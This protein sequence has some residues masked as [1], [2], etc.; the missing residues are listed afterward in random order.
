VKSVGKAIA[1]IPIIGHGYCATKCAAK[2][3]IVSV[4]A[5]ALSVASAAL[6]TAHYV[7]KGI[8][9]VWAKILELGSMIFK[10]NN[11]TVAGTLSRKPGLTLVVDVS[12]FG[13]RLKWSLRIGSH[14]KVDVTNVSK[15]ALKDAKKI[16]SKESPEGKVLLQVAKEEDDIWL[17]ANALSGAFD[18][19]RTARRTMCQHHGDRRPD[20]E[21][22]L[23]S[24]DAISQ[25]SWITC[26][27]DG[28]C[29]VNDEL[30]HHEKHPTAGKDPS[31]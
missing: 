26:S 25:E 5:A 9:R 30:E 20:L 12:I 21:A 29:R 10:I 6:K 28:K 17:V 2:K 14:K 1:K 11:I 3:A 16:A 7:A 24:V 27:S 31:S 8:G 13:K 19:Y 18:A 23:R 15:E 22:C 4:A